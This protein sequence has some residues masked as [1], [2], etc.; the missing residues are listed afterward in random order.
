M[1]V[2]YFVQTLW[3]NANDIDKQ[4]V[5]AALT[6]GR[7]VIPIIKKGQQALSQLKDSLIALAADSEHH[8][9]FYTTEQDLMMANY[10]PH[11]VSFIGSQLTGQQ[12][13]YVHSILRD[14]AADIQI[15]YPFSR[16]FVKGSHEERGDGREIQIYTD[17]SSTHQSNIIGW[18]RKS[19]FMSSLQFSFEEKLFG[20]VNDLEFLAI[21]SAVS[22][23]RNA[24][25]LVVYSDSMNAVKEF[26]RLQKLR[27]VAEVL[28]ALMRAN[29]LVEN[30]HAVAKSIASGC[31]KVQWVRAHQND[32]WNICADQMVRYA[33]RRMKFVDK[34][35]V[36]REVKSLL[37]NLLSNRDV[38]S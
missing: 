4:F 11:N 1:I 32:D 15:A 36:R 16:P 33:R 24:S 12:Y 30:G 9:V 28:D 35:L 34:K 23:Y 31:V 3:V 14:I 10:I 5:I 8:F 38:F 37:L 22:A 21:C 2:K 7:E 29:P 17:V 19:M 13:D 20:S 18:V 6:D 26:E 27:S 25:N